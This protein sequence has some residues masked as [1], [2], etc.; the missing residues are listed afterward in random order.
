MTFGFFLVDMFLFG[1]VRLCF[2]FVGFISFFSLLVDGFDCI[3]VH[4]FFWVI[5]FSGGVLGLAE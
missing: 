2:G 5:F 1:S 3:S 4:A